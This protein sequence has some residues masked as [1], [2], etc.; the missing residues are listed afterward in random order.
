MINE[1]YN[2]VIDDPRSEEKKAMDYTTASLTMGDIVLNWKEYN[3][4][5]FKPYIIQNQDGSL[6][7]VSQGTSKILA[8]HEVKEGKQYV[9][10]C[11][12]FIYTRRANYPDGGMYLPDALKIAC[13][14][15]SCKESLMLCDNKGESYM[16]DKTEAPECVIDA[17]KYKG[18]AYFQITGGIDEI[19]KVIE[20][21]YG[22]LMGAR[23]DYDEWTDV[24]FIK[25]NSKKACGHG[26]AGTYYCLYN[27]EKAIMIEDSWG[28]GYGL[29]GVRILT[30]SFIKERVF[31]VGYVTSLVDV[32]YVF[33]KTL[34]FGSRG[35]DV[36]MLQTKLNITAD[37]I[38]GKDTKLA[39]QGFQLR[40]HLIADG[41]VGPL[42]NAIL[43][44]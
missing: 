9:R 25:P 19:A 20:Q 17:K 4:E 14:F 36:K 21:G 35:L 44:K 24:P 39:V 18:K 7:C 23:F 22:V 5:D 42:T 26:F 43:N 2:G 15:G 32:P 12:K 13:D 27:G 8:I 33:T 6:S 1:N 29:G 30:E 28:P 38:F 11:P 41:I 3:K 16:N 10:L 40:N 37:G 31:Y 34:K